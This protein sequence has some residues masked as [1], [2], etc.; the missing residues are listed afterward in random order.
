MGFLAN[1]DH[2]LEA[3]GSPSVRRRSLSSML[4]S[5]SVLCRTHKTKDPDQA[6]SGSHKRHT[7]HIDTQ[8]PLGYVMDCLG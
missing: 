2:D 1:Q 3:A 6:F 4:N 5:D 7:G 8:I